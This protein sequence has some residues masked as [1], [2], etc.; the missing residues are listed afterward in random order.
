ME[1][2]FTVLKKATSEPKIW[3]EVKRTSLFLVPTVSEHGTFD[4]L[5][6]VP[7]IVNALLW[8]Y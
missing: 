2:P 1:S 3:A 5:V 7:R 4:L 8:E 6:E